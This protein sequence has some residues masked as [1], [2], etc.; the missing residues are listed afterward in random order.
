MHSHDL[1]QWRHAHRYET[2][3]EASAERRTQVVLVL[4]LVTMVA[5]LVAG[6][7]FNSMALTADGWH[8]STHAGAMGI[9]AF[10]Y[11]YARRHADDRSFAFGTGKVT[12]LAGF[13]SAI[14]LGVVAVAMVWESLARLTKV[15]VIDFNGALLVASLGLIVN[16]ASAWILGGSDHDHHHHDHDHDHHHGHDHHQDHNLRAAYVHVLADAFTSILAI[17]A[18]LLGKYAGAW[19]MDPVMGLVG[20]AVVG[21]WAIGLLRQTGGVLLD[22]GD[23]GDLSAQ[24]RAAIEADADNALSDL[25]LWRV[26]PGHWAAIVSVV[27][28]IPRD[29]SHYKQLLVGFDELSHVTV[30]VHTCSGEGCIPG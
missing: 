3:I 25:H 14:V 16:L 26:G 30:E 6:W 17:V 24:V 12:D 13:A 8:M 4:T 21:S 10:S 1:S 22:R 20:A 15:Q 29:P 19:W 2:G 28:H 11:V 18:L 7:A 23:G 5:E 9:A 27:T